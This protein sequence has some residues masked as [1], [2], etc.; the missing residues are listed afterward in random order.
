MKEKAFEIVKLLSVIILAVIWGGA[1]LAAIIWFH[2]KGFG[3]RGTYPV[4]MSFDI[5]G[6]LLRAGHGVYVRYGEGYYL[7]L[8]ETVNLLDISEESHFRG[9]R[10]L[11]KLDDNPY[12]YYFSDNRLLKGVEK[13][14]G[15]GNAFML[16]EGTVYIS[17]KFMTEELKCRILEGTDAENRIFISRNSFR[18]SKFDYSWAEKDENSY[19]AHA[20]GGIDGLDYSNS[21]EAFE[22]SYRKGFKVFEADLEYTSDGELVLI[23][24]WERALLRRLFGMDLPDDNVETPLSLSEFKSQKIYGKYTPLSFKELLRLMKENPDVYLVI[25]G[26]Y[27]EEE[28]VRKEY[29]D[30]VE[31]AE[32]IDPLLLNRMIPQIY[33]KGMYDWIMD[34]YDWKSMIFSWYMYGSAGL[35][36]EPLFDFCEERGIKICAMKDALEN[37]LLDREAFRR[38]LMIFVYTVNSEED[39][40]R[41]F[42]NGVKGIYT[43]FLSDENG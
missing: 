34:T 4:Q 43:D 20:L 18:E 17:T 19:I 27:N 7:P 15:C 42:G 37:A 39:R 33:N 23:H 40:K 25:D 14:E 6:E 21:L 35:E 16:K 3:S 30:I 29:R 11:I 8:T 13:I 12:T 2:F 26:K 32:S 5:N 1:V 28:E 36:P 22:E 31:Y 9:N 24:N 10:L 38:D 41:L